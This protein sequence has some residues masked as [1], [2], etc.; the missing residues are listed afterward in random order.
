M[1]ERDARLVEAARAALRY[2]QNR[3]GGASTNGPN[4][5]VFIGRQLANA[6]NDWS[7]VPDPRVAN[8]EI[9]SRYLSKVR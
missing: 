6:L 1:S 9:V 3:L 8:E 5:E 4:D 2:F 7:D